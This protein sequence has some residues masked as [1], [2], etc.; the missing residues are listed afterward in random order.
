MSKTYRAENSRTA[1][2]HSPRRPPEPEVD[3]ALLDYLEDM[4]A[5]RIEAS[6]EFFGMRP[7][8]SVD[9]GLN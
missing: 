8:L 2:R 6:T 3:L 5:D 1:P 7:S 4:E 9:H